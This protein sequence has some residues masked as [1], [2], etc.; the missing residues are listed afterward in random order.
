MANLN[1]YV[2]IPTAV[3]P[4]PTVLLLYLTFPGEITFV[5][6]K[7]KDIIPLDNFGDNDPIKLPALEFEL[8]K[9]YRLK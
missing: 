9:L 1:L 8:S 4:N 5:F 2:P 3:V 6:S 7:F